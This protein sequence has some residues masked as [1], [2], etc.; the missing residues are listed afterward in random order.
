[1]AQA[2]DPRGLPPVILDKLD[3]PRLERQS[4]TVFILGRQAQVNIAVGLP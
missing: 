3:G 1:M 2:A 4:A